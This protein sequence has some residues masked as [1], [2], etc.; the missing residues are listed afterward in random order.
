MSKI[1]ALAIASVFA[2]A[3]CGGAPALP[4]VNAAA[5]Q[6][7]GEAAKAAEGAAAEATKAA[8]G[9]AAEAAAALPA[10]PEAPATPAAPEAPATPAAPEAPAAPATTAPTTP[11][12]TGSNVDPF[13][14]SKRRA[15]NCG[16]PF[17]ISAH[18]P[19]QHAGPCIRIRGPYGL[20]LD[21]TGTLHPRDG[22]S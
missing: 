1:L 3:A 5:S 8:E 16:P 9:A 17:F 21:D 18:S 20:C 19:R 12:D 6:A 7:T 15:R 14:V 13:F 4:D 11:Y 22:R 10:A 2:L